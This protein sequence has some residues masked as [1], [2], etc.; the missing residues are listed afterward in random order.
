MPIKY[1]VVLLNEREDQPGGGGA[2]IMPNP[3]YYLRPKTAWFNTEAEALTAG[4]LLD[5]ELADGDMFK[6][7]ERAMVVRYTNGRELALI[8]G[9]AMET[10]Y[11]PPGDNEIHCASVSDLGEGEVFIFLV[12]GLP[13]G[14]FESGEFFDYISDGI[15]TGHS[16][17]RECFN[18]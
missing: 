9:G 12:C 7:V 16:L 5:H 13:S 11:S 2:N 4:S 6:D 14:D 18:V 10:H 1:R 8:P 3:P 15:N 17:C